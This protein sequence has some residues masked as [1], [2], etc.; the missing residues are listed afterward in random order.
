MDSDEQTSYDGV[1]SNSE[2]KMDEGDTQS[3]SVSSGIKSISISSSHDSSGDIDGVEEHRNMMLASLLEDYI[4][5]RAAEYLNATNPG[6]NYTRQSP[7]VQPLARQLFADASR[8]LSSNGVISDLAT[9]DAVRNSRRQYLSAL[10]NLV[11]GSQVP[12]SH[13]PNAMRDLVLGTSQLSLMPHP[14]NDLKLTLQ[15]PPVRSHYQSSFQEGAL[16][17][18]GGFGKVYKCFNPLDRGTYA[19]KKIQ[20]SPKLGKRFRDG[21]LEELQ[22]ILREVQALATLDHPNIVRYHAT[23]LE[24]PHQPQPTEITHDPTTRTNV[25]QR[26]QLLLDHQPF[27]QDD[28]DGAEQSLSGGVVFAEDT[29]SCRDSKA[30]D[31]LANDLQW[32]EQRTSSNPAIESLSLSNTSDIFTDGKSKLSNSNEKREAFGAVG[33]ILYIQ[34]S[35]YPLTL[36]QYISLSSGGNDAVRHCFHL[37]PSLRL[38]H[39]IHAGLQ[40][41]HAKGFIHRDIKPGNIFLSLPD[42]E[43]RG[44]YC[45]LACNSCQ[46]KAE[47]LSPQWLNPRI[48]DFGLVTQLARGEL[49]LSYASDDGST[50][51]DRPV[52]T[53]YYRPPPS[54]NADNEKVD[55][56]ALG[57]V[58]IEMICPCTT[59][60]ERVDMLKGLQKGYVPKSLRQGLKDEGYPPEVIDEV[61]L[62]AEAMVCPDSEARWSSQQVDEA[63]ERVIRRCESSYM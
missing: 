49:P 59:A 36:A 43:P 58:F 13:L 15:L 10:D 50:T 41:I 60:M 52:G 37:A 53:T 39:A 34:M 32:F 11:A 1:P 31:Q 30:N 40:Y 21:K 9:S 46:V 61:I 18:K 35:L 48:G 17:G 47:I 54:K 44:G 8:T 26:Q 56:F 27:C 51:S 25:G 24:E 55:I 57:V 4:R 42:T 28:R 7:E 23:W 62:L 19:V 2:R 14:S 12:T 38:L 5:T 29:P 63:I 6:H 22:H 3:I 20:L 45:S 33:H 16:L